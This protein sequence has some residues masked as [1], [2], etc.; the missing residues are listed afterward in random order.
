MLPR[1]PVIVNRVI[2]ERAAPVDLGGDD[3]VVAFPAELLDAFAHYFFRLAG[4][5][6]F[7]AVEEVDAGVVGGFHAGEGVFWTGVSGMDGKVEFIRGAFG[8][9]IGRLGSGE[10]KVPFSTCPPYVSQPPRAMT[11][12]WRPERPRKRYCI[13]GVDSAPMLSLI[14]L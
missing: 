3:N 5:V 12:T 2:A 14:G 1:Q 10:G 7:R 8:E 13:L 11:E 4:G 6:A 9:G